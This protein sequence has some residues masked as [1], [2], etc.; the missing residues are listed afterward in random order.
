[1]HTPHHY[2]ILMFLL[3]VQYDFLLKIYMFENF[4]KL[5]IYVEKYISLSIGVIINEIKKIR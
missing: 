2:L 3:S 5:M 1:M 4:E